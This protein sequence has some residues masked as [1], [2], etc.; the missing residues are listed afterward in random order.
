MRNFTEEKQCRNACL[1]GQHMH[2]CYAVRTVNFPVQ[3]LATKNYIINFTFCGGLGRKL[4][5]T[6]N[7]T[8]SRA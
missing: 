3:L 5:L 4:L 1:L 7:G 2:A 6:L 8:P